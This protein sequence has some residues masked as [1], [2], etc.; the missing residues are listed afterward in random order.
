LVEGSPSG[1]ARIGSPMG[2]ASPSKPFSSSPRDRVGL[3]R[4]PRPPPS[5]MRI[6]SLEMEGEVGHPV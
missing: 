6:R 1:P 5:A 2:P 4:G 3:V